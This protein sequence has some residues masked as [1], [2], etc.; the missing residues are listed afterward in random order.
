MKRS[1]GFEHQFPQSL[2]G[3]KTVTMADH[4]SSTSPTDGLGETLGALA[5]KVDAWRQQ[6]TSIVNELQRLAALT[7]SLLEEL[8]TEAHVSVKRGGGRPKGYRASEETRAKLRA[9]WKRRKALGP[10]RL[11][12][13]RLPAET[14]NKR[15][16]ANGRRS[17]ATNAKR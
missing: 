14:K 2:A 3:K 7:A 12:A 10:G 4:R 8:G 13:S 16:A 17:S 6:R 11:A 5:S 1:A 9:A 15:P